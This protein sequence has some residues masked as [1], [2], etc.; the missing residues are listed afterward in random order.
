MEFIPLKDVAVKPLDARLRALGGT[1]KPALDLI[2]FGAEYERAFAFAC[3][4][5]VVCDTDAEARALARDGERRL[6]VCF[7]GWG[8]LFCF[9][10][11]RGGCRVLHFGVQTNTPQST[12][13]FTSSS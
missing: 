11:G 6:K 5:A 8:V 3:G 2:E 1:A 9:A 12:T 10:C 4:A 13:T 7:G